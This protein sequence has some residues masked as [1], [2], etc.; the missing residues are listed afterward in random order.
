MDPRDSY[1]NCMVC[2]LTGD[3]AVR[4]AVSATRT[5]GEAQKLAEEQIARLCIVIEELVINLFDHGGVTRADQIEL[6]LMAEPQGIRVVLAD[7]GAPFDPRSAEPGQGN[8]DRGGGVGIDVVRAWAEIVGYEVTAEG[9][10][11]EFLL[12]L[13]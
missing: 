12:P 5:F 10:R 7:P 1:S 8:S 9:N 4:Q 6:M 13:H 2:L 11:L 3:G